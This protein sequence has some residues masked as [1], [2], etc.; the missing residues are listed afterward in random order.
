MSHRRNVFTDA[1]PALTAA[2]SGR[3]R[4]PPG[5]PWPGMVGGHHAGPLAFATARSGGF[6]RQKIL[7]SEPRRSVTGSCDGE[8]VCRRPCRARCGWRRTA[9]R[10]SGLIHP[11]ESP[12]GSPRL[13]RPSASAA[14]S[15]PADTLT[16][17]PSNAEPSTGL[18]E[19]GSHHG[20]SRRAQAPARGAYMITATPMRQIAAP[21]R[22]HRSGRNL[23]TTMPQA[24]DPA[25]KIPP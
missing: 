4:R 8:Q 13:P 24:R 12:G 6:E 19:D 7:T 1:L 11:P 16:A 9:T 25:T 15:R 2:A 10:A 22:S 20:G 14:L 21:M 23:S 18:I 17:R 5:C 3:R